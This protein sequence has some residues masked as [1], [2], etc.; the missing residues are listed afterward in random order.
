YCGALGHGDEIE[1]TRP[2]LLSNLKNHLAVQGPF[3]GVSD[4]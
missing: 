2:E 3:E 4:V 1:K